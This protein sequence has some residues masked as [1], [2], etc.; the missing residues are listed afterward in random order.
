MTSRKDVWG[1]Q[2]WS[3]GIALNP[4]PE[5]KKTSRQKGDS[6]VELFIS[7]H[8]RLP[9]RG[10]MAQFLPATSKASRWSLCA[11]MFCLECLEMSR[12]CQHFSRHCWSS[13]WRDDRE[14]TR[15]MDGSNQWTCVS[16]IPNQATQHINP[17]VIKRG[18]GRSS[19]YR[20]SSHQ[21]PQFWILI[22]DFPANHVTLVCTP[23]KSAEHGDIRGPRS[24]II[25]LFS[26]LPGRVG[27]AEAK[28]FFWKWPMWGFP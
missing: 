6:L 20:W 13:K 22:E 25:V 5:R 10:S 8:L 11:G 24:P 4:F 1:S 16:F 19:I 2:L 21:N 27:G 12:A 7:C 15:R 17:P 28:L 14:Q 3:G 23:P 26:T 9:R 18:N